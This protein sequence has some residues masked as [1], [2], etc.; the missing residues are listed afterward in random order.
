MW[1]DDKKA[2]CIFNAL[3]NVNGELKLRIIFRKINKMIIIFLYYPNR[4]PAVE[5]IAAFL[6]TGKSKEAVMLLRAA[7]YKKLTIF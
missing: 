4:E 2:E 7:R 6:H 5:R 3:T 1:F